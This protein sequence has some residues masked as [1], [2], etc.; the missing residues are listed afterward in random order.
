MLLV[1]VIGLWIE[2]FQ[3]VLEAIKGLQK[4]CVAIFITSDKCY[5]NIERNYGSRETDR[6]GGKDPY[7]G[8]KGAAELV[9][10]SY[11]QSF[12]NKSESNVRVGVGRAGNVIGGGD[13]APY[14]VVPDCVK[15]WSDN[16]SAEIRNPNATRPWQHVLEP[17]SGYITLALALSKKPDLNGEAF[18]FGPPADQNH[19]VKELVDEMSNYWSGSKWI[20]KSKNSS[21]T[22][23]AGLL[24]LNCEKALNTLGW[25]ASLDF[26]ETAQWTADW[27]RS[28]YKK[29]PEAS[30][31]VT[32]DQII[33][34]IKLASER[35]VLK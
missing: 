14:R 32:K 19:S 2:L 27:Y 16:R 26:K 3:I 35:K 29:G 6:L 10:N 11:V 33:E 21:V 1:E 9:I 34:Y 12:F 22:Y 8:S 20:N 15:A 5:D 24:K 13:W 28:Y 7:S 18:N 25:K 31:H 17:L 23:E 4:E 30:W